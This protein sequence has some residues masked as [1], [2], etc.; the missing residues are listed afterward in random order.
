MK[1]KKVETVGDDIEN[2]LGHGHLIRCFAI[3]PIADNKV[4]GFGR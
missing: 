2:G 4:C 3:S 1:T